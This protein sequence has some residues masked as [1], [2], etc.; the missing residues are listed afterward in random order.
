MIPTNEWKWFGTHGHFV[1]GHYCRFH[2]CTQVGKYLISSLGEYIHPRH[3]N[4]G[5]EIGCG[6]KYETMV[7]FAG[8]PCSEPSCNCGLPLIDGHEI[9]M[10][11]Y[12]VRG[13]AN[14][15]HLEMCKKYAEMQ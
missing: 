11:A 13:E 5:E 9:D 7:F 2:L 6:R 8:E 15:G 3:S 10:N 4:G 1:C 14:R 12:N